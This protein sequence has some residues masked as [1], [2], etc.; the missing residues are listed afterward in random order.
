MTDDDIFAV[1]YE[2]GGQW[3]PSHLTPNEVKRVHSI[4][5]KDGTTW[6]EINGFRP[7]FMDY[8]VAGMKIVWEHMNDPPTP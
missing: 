1:T 4:L 3:Q 7:K 8:T 6:D 5:F 2:E